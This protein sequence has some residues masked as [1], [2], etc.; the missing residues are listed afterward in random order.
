MDYV[1]EYIDFT[2]LMISYA[3]DAKVIYKT[4]KQ[5]KKL[6]AVLCLSAIPN[7][8]QGWD[9]MGVMVVNV[10]DSSLW[11]NKNPI[12]AEDTLEFYM[13]SGLVPGA[14]TYTGKV[15]AIFED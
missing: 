12:Y 10:P 8:I 7:V 6:I 1:F 5:Y 4:S 9:S 14:C 11:S 3:F 15:L 2:D 13:V